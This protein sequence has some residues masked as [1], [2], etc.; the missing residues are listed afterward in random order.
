MLHRVFHWVQVEAFTADSRR[1]FEE[2]W[3]IGESLVKQE[4]YIDTKASHK[5]WLMGIHKQG[6]LR[7]RGHRPSAGD[8]LGTGEFDLP[9]DSVENLPK[10]S[11]EG[12]S[13]GWGVNTLACR[14]MSTATTWETGG[15]A[16]QSIFTFTDECLRSWHIS[17]QVHAKNTRWIL[18]KL[19][20]KMWNSP[21]KPPVLN[22][23]TVSPVKGQI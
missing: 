9:V 19:S 18:T 11:A 5:V 23:S 2:L 14:E 6:S 16:L 15:W 4:H 7:V 10:F 8:S 20:W 13:S 1:F 3:Q 21:Q 22:F 12:L 17:W